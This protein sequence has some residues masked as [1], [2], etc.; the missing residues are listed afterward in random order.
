[1]AKT[2]QQGMRE[3]TC[4]IRIEDELN[5]ELFSSNQIELCP[6]GVGVLI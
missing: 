3:R 1:M 5:C 6:A 4:R 2:E